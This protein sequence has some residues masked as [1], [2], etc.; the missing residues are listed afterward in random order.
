MHLK[1]N[2]QIDA[3]LHLVS[4]RHIVAR[5]R[6]GAWSLELEAFVNRTY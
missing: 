2:Y 5:L 3:P 4:M 6:L 1:V